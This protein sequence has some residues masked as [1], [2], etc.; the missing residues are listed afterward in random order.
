MRMQQTGKVGRGGAAS[1]AAFRLR[2]CKVG[3]KLSRWKG[4]QLCWCREEKPGNKMKN[5]EQAKEGRAVRGK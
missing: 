1:D 4:S 3:A 2:A 5:G